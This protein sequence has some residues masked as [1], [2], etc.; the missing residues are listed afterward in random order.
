MK[1]TLLFLIS[2]VIILTGFAAPQKTGYLEHEVQE[3]MRSVISNQMSIELKNETNH[4]T[5]FLGRIL[6]KLE[7]QFI[8]ND[9]RAELLA[10]GREDYTAD[11]IIEEIR[12][13]GR[14]D[15]TAFD[16]WCKKYNL[17][18]TSIE[19]FRQEGAV[20]A[21]GQ[22]VQRL[23]R[24]HRA[25]KSLAEAY[26][27]TES[28]LEGTGTPFTAKLREELL[29][30]VQNNIDQCYADDPYLHNSLCAARIT[31]YKGWYFNNVVRGGWEKYL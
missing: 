9:I 8:S 27:K 11:K 29:R 22:I 15:F 21:P 16:S 4:G 30:F 26:K 18:F 12:A 24:L 7:L 3:Q 28:F 25:A 10:I 14:E 20:L 19:S 2:C 1:K 23:E 6:D 17:Y 13:I 31:G 5:A